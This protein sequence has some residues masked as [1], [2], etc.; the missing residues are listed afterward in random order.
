[1]AKMT[2]YV[3]DNLKERM[4]RIKEDVNW[5]NIA[6]RG[7]EQKLGEIASRKEKK[8]MADAV[9]RLRAWKHQHESRLFKEG[10]DWGQDWAKDDASV[11]QLKRLE[12]LYNRLS[13]EPVYNWEHFFA[14]DANNAYTVY[15][16]LYFQL[17]PDHNGDRESARDFWE[18]A[19]G[20]DGDTNIQE[21]ELVRGF[22]EG[23]LDIWRSVKHQL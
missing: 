11:T 7:F 19:V 16:L 22:A 8:K 15:E 4:D 14:F 12:M 1:M 23:A 13:N 10:F 18:R 2:I 3:P 9:Q 6:C 5:S 20:D 17:E 21:G